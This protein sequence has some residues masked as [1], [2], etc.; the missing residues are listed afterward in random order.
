VCLA[1][2]ESLGGLTKTAGK[3]VVDESELQNALESLKD[4]HL[5]LALGIGVDFDFGRLGDGGLGLFSVRLWACKLH[6]PMTD[7]AHFNGYIVYEDL[8][9]GD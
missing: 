3:S 5:A 9:I 8:N 2:V 7:I 1:A 6:I 4:G